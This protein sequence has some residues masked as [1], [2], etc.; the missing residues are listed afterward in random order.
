MPAPS[1][2]PPAS[3]AVNR[4]AVIRLLLAAMVASVHSGCEVRD[5]VGAR[6]PVER[7]VAGAARLLDRVPTGVSRPVVG[8]TDPRITA[9]VEF[10]EGYEAGVRRARAEGRPMVLVF[11]AGWCRHS[12]M[13]LQRTLLDP[14]VVAL[15]RRYVCVAIDADREPEVCRRYAVSA[16][17]TLIVVDAVGHAGPPTVGRPSAADLVVV[18]EAGDRGDRPQRVAADDDIVPR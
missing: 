2:P 14:R 1:I 8:T 6:P 7:H 16:F 18:L 9:T 15:S 12:G 11:K 17:P 3:R 13:L 10:V 5:E 4:S